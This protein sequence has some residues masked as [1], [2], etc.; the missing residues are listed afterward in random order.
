MSSRRASRPHL[1]TQISTSSTTIGQ[2]SKVLDV[3]NVGTFRNDMKEG[4]GTLYL[5]NGEYFVGMFEADMVSGD[6]VY[7]S[8]SEGN[9]RATWRNNKILQ[10]D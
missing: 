10:D 2:R 5:S 6:G 3:R 9:I 4:P 8:M 7:H 1:T